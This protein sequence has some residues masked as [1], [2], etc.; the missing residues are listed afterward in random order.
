MVNIVWLLV[1]AIFSF[2]L[3]VAI[4]AAMQLNGRSSDYEK[5]CKG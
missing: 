4:M 3:G 5:C 1:V 2:G